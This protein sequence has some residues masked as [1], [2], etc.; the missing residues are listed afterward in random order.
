MAEGRATEQ[1]GQSISGLAELG[2]RHAGKLRQMKDAEG[3]S[4][5]L[6][7]MDSN[8]TEFENS[9]ITSQ[10]YSGWTDQWKSNINSWGQQI[11]DLDISDEAKANLRLKYNEWA[12]AKSDRISTTAALKSVESTKGTIGTNLNYYASRGDWIGYD[13][14]INDA[15]QTGIFRPDQI[16]QLRVDGMTKKAEYDMKGTILS[17]PF[18]ALDQLEQE[19]YIANN[20]GATEELRLWGIGKAKEGIRM[21]QSQSARELSNNIESG[22]ITT[23]EQLE[24]EIKRKGPAVD[25]STA[26]RI[27]YHF[28]QTRAVDPDVK[29]GVVDNLN[30][31]YDSYTR[32]EISDEEYRVAHGLIAQRVYEYGSRPGVGALREQ[33]DK[34][35]P[36]SWDGRKLK[37]S[38]IEERMR[39][40]QTIGKTFLDQGAFGEISDEDKE[41]LTPYELATKQ[42]DIFS[43]RQ[44]VEAAMQTWLSKDENQNASEE[45]ISAQYKKTYMQQTSSRI[46][47][48]GG[49][50]ATESEFGDYLQSQTGPRGSEGDRI[51]SYG[52]SGDT[53][54]DSNSTAGIGAWVSSDEQERI[55]NGEITPNRLREGDLAVSR[56]VERRFRAMGIQPGDRVTVKLD[57]GTAQTGRWMDRTAE[58]YN[59]KQLTGRF[60]VYSPEGPSPLNGRKVVDWWKYGDEDV[61]DPRG[62]YIPVPTEVPGIQAVIQGTSLKGKKP[63]LNEDTDTP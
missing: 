24:E 2:F 60:D 1:L 6:T 33:V 42:T 22:Q 38:A 27:R 45:E 23:S 3:A 7:Q 56:D 37:Q 58:S 50:W 20:P 17:N 26:D 52:Y 8:A 29:F 28:G 15:Q 36:A 46:I 35:D 12:G 43:N 5:F 10:D 21:V 30:R 34:M 41:N 11:D 61:I 62:Q 48:P 14:T 9:L 51:T 57:D 13:R 32:N 53:T 39:S 59:G 31:L 19:G 4:A 16:H 47:R 44:K 55:K 54:P 40:V 18:Q 25:E 63:P 49:A